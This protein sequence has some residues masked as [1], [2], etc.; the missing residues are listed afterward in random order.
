LVYF[1]SSNF[2]LREVSSKQR[3]VG[4]GTAALAQNNRTERKADNALD[5]SKVGQQHYSFDT[6]SKTYVTK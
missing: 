2:I 4:S 6:E 5:C 1:S 3:T